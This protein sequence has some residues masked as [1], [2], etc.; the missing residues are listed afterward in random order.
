M[1]NDISIINQKLKI[2]LNVRVAG[3]FIDN[4]RILLQKNDTFYTLIG[5]RVKFNESSKDAF[6]REMKEELGIDLED[7]DIKLI[8]LIENFFDCDNLTYHEFLFLYRVYDN[9]GLDSKNN[10]KTLDKE[11]SYNKWVNI[12]ELDKL[13]FKPDIVKNNFKHNYLKHIIYKR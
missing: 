12:S 11:S 10:F 5:G 4:D 2:K 8:D 7:K 6:K 3:I 13:D 1:D 9:K